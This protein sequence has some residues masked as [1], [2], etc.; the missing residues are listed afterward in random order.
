MRA[1]VT[2][3]VPAMAAKFPVSTSS[4]KVAASGVG[5]ALSGMAVCPATFC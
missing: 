5:G 3:A 1:S 2:Q 4:V